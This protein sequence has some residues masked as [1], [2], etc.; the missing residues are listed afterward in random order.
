MSDAA[1]PLSGIE[2]VQSVESVALGARSTDA[3]VPL[4][5]PW[6]SSVTHTSWM[7]A[8]GFPVTCAA[9]SRFVPSC[10]AP[11]VEIVGGAESAGM[12]PP[13]YVCVLLL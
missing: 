12:L 8:A 5:P 11:T 4:D 6:P 2:P 7:P 9:T 1:W 3:Q 13:P 10:T